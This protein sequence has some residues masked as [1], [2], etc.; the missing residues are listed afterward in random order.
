MPKSKLEK[1]HKPVE[2][3]F[4]NYIQETPEDETMLGMMTG[5]VEASRYQQQH[6]LELTK[7]IVG[8]SGEAS[9][10]EEEIYSIFKRASRVILESTPL[11]KVL[12]EI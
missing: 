9:L 10:S 11:N 7:L 5:L 12:E 8:K 2:L 1:K 4:M 6:S 3:D